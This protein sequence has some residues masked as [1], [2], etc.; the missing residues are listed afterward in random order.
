M[1]PSTNMVTNIEEKS[2]LF[3]VQAYRQVGR[4]KINFMDFFPIYMGN[5]ILNKVILQWANH[6]NTLK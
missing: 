4:K 1:K 6:Y 3:N 2:T 5:S